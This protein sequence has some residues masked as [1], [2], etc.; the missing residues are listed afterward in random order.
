[1]SGRQVQLNQELARKTLAAD[2]LAIVRDSVDEF[3]LVNCGTA[4]QRLAK[5]PDTH[6]HLSPTA[7]TLPGVPRVLQ[8]QFARLLDAAAALV[9]KDPR[10]VESR[11]LASMLWACGKL[12]LGNRAADLVKG[13]EAA[14]VMHA[15][16]FNPQELANAV[17]GAAKLGLDPSR[18][19]LVHAIA[20]AIAV[21]LPKAPA[22]PSGP[23]RDPKGGGPGGWRGVRVEWTSQGVSN[24]AMSLAK[25]DADVTHGEGVSTTGDGFKYGKVFGEVCSAVTS[26]ADDFNPQEVAN[27]LHALAKLTAGD[28]EGDGGGRTVPGPVE[29]T[30]REAAEALA[31][32]ITIRWIEAQRLEPQHVA[33]MSWACAKMGAAGGDDLAGALAKAAANLAPRM[34]TQE[35]SMVAWSAAAFGS[36]RWP[37]DCAET[38]ARAFGD[39]ATDATP[40][41]LAKASMAYAKLGTLHPKLMDAVADAVLA[42]EQPFAASLNPQDVANLAWSFSKLGCKKKRLFDA[43]SA[44]FIAHLR[45]DDDSFSSQQLTMIVCAFGLLGFKDES[46]LNTAM[47]A[48]SKER[49]A[50]F[51][52][53]DLTNTAWALAALGVNAEAKPKLVE[54]IG[55]TA[56]KRLDD[57]NSQELLKFLGAFERLGGSDVRL[58]RAVSKQ[59]IL[60]YEFP[61][62]STHVPSSS[63]VKL[64]SKTPTSY[65]GTDRVRVDDSCGGWGRGNTGVALWEGSFVLAEWLSRQGTPTGSPEMAEVMS[66]AWGPNESGGWRGMI[67]VELG[68]G[69]GLPSI[70]ASKLGLEMVATDGALTYPR[71]APRLVFS[72]CSRGFRMSPFVNP[73]TGP[74]M[75]LE[76][77]IGRT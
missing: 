62:L 4:L 47:G 52:P 64:S 43:L 18:S 50:E 66:G 35:L 38:V 77:Q 46:M 1:M 22:A 39:R 53:R 32:R 69:L 40:R 36:G 75:S 70:V 72:R 45:D 23:R 60:S 30:A 5:C 68:A 31:S 10:H 17:W 59:R 54:R 8:E 56:R 16:K 7:S 33:N 42:L 25:L 28:G 26:R 34:N 20:D 61:A 11:Q 12:E 6:R 49:V 9:R 29:R 74:S 76:F 57:F 58:A 3:N 67:G 24:V 2:V 65:Q 48:M 55:R 19:E 27:I 41:Q 14:A 21:S 15:S 63:S 37:A 71:F 44:A 73:S 51:N 13:I